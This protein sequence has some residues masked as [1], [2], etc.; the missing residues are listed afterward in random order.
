[1]FLRCSALFRVGHVC[2]VIVALLCAATLPAAAREKDTTDY[3]V[4]LITNIP[5]AE[6]EVA[7]VVS[8]VAQ[9]GIIRGTKE[10]NKD[11]YIS[12]A[13]AAPSSSLFPA[14]TEGGKVFFKIRKQAIDPRNFKGSNDVGTL[15]VRYVVQ[16]EGDKHTVLRIDAV[17]VEDFRRA[18]HL[19]NGSVESAEFKVIQDHL[20]AIELMK[21]QTAE[22]EQERKE[23]LA[24]KNFGM[25]STA[26]PPSGA[27]TPPAPVEPSTAS[28]ANEP[29]HDTTPAVAAAPGE[30]L[31]EHV[32]N[33]RRAVE[34]LVKPPGAPLKSAPFHSASTLTTLR[35]GTEVLIVITTPYWFGVETHDGQHGWI[36]RE[37]LELLP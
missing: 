18:V 7:Q 36:P 33:L 37:Q 13:E 28:I 5:L 11:E 14:W 2:A 17:F 9:N 35:P 27:S 31:E 1:M 12:G 20:D 15:A 6:S 10:Y 3:G 4:G 32:A 34:R 22:A 26:V 21:R 30:T 25:E 8:D 24:K 16:P 29:E 19:S 23:R